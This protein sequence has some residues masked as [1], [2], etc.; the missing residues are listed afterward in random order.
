MQYLQAGV[1]FDQ[2]H[3]AVRQRHMEQ[4]LRQQNILAQADQGF[5]DKK[6]D[7]VCPQQHDRWIPQGPVQGNG[8]LGT[9][10]P[11]ID[12]EMHRAEEL[13][14]GISLQ[15]SSTMLSQ[16][17]GQDAVPHPTHTAQ[18]LQSHH[19]V[20]AGLLG[21]KLTNQVALEME[22]E[23]VFDAPMDD[24]EPERSSTQLEIPRW[25]VRSKKAA[26]D[27]VRR[28]QERWP[29]WAKRVD[30]QSATSGSFRPQASSGSFRSP[31]TQRD[32]RDGVV[33]EGSNQEKS[34][35]SQ[36]R[37]RAQPH[38][39]LYLEYLKEKTAWM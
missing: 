4:A 36:I 7:T 5:A 12:E 30:Y 15:G 10:S 26:I 13:D 8:L 3:P 25:Q 1:K 16:R 31:R 19:V 34:P 39:E 2:E 28:Q 9:P 6:I 35:Q 21:W 38:S 18:Q 24:G 11:Y 37:S 23:E 32:K 22:E 14:G 17:S 29:M 33:L 20:H 27:S